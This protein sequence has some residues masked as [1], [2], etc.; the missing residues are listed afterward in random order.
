MTGYIGTGGYPD[1]PD[2]PPSRK[3]Y[4]FKETNF[5]INGM[6]GFRLNPKQK[7]L[8]YELKLFD[9]SS[10]PER[11]GNISEFTP[12]AFRLLFHLK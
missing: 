11:S 1:Y 7:R 6:F 12:I 4:Y 5:A 9:F 10:V 3:N 2:E 8:G